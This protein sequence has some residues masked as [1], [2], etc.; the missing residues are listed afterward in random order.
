[1]AAYLVVARNG[2]ESLRTRWFAGLAILTLSLAL[3]AAA[4]RRWPARRVGIRIAGW[5]AIPPALLAYWSVAR[6]TTVIET[7]IV[8]Q[9][10]VVA[11]TKTWTG[12]PVHERAT[13]RGSGL[14]DSGPLTP[15]GKRHGPWQRRNGLRTEPIWYWYG[16]PVT[17]GEFALRNR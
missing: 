16:E 9:V 15:S 17:E 2:G 6:S 4:R 3:A 11:V 5:A 1:M 12:V 14:V 8:N 10:L 13:V 7:R